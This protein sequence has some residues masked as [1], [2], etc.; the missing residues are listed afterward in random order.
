MI[1]RSTPLLCLALT[2]GG[3][4]AIPSALTGQTAATENW[5]GTWATAVVARPPQAAASPIPAPKPLHFNNQTLRQIVRAS[6]GGERIRIVLSNTFG[7]APLSIGAARVALRDKDAAIVQ[8]SSR[9]L[10]FGGG[11]AATIPPG[12]VIVSDPVTLSV[13]AF[14]DLA[15]DIFLPGD[16]AA[17]ASP[18]T[19]H[20]AALQTNYLSEPGNHTGSPQLPVSTTTT[21]W[22][23]LARVEV[24]APRTTGA[25]VTLGD[26]ITDGTSSTVDTNNR[27]PNHL[28]RRLAAQK[29]N[30]AVLNLGIAGNRVLS[31]GMGVNALARFDR[32]VVAQP[33][34]THVIVL[35]G[36]N[37]VGMAGMMRD[38]PRPTAAQLIAGH[39]QIIARARA[40]GLKVFGATLLPCEGV[41]FAGYWTPEGEKVR[42]ALNEWMR[43]SKEYDGVIDFD[44]VMRD[45]AAP[46]KLLPKYD[47]GDRLHPSDAGYQAMADAVNLELLKSGGAPQRSGSR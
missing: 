3:L 41:I 28:A 18:V 40:R 4:L 20:T 37:D 31:D 17:G 46:T 1:R 36:I 15:V 32:D 19:M 44:A 24:V 27:W 9:A 13:A 25:I 21:S 11:T 2:L 39:R 43:T 7:T 30:M 45:P 23:F 29:I 33:G 8:S 14:A 38:T 47:S 34:V 12:A 26:S 22:F 5:V 6:I 42:Q 16:T 10:T 35:E